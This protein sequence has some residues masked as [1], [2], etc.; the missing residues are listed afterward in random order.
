MRR[1]KA[2]VAISPKKRRGH[3]THL[4]RGQ[5]IVQV[6]VVVG[7]HLHQAAQLVGLQRLLQAGVPALD[8]GVLVVRRVAHAAVAAAEKG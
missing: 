6:L 5:E 7:E 1:Q 3:R 4:E 8:L 2:I